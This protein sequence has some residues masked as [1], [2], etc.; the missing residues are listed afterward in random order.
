MY[1]FIRDSYCI[2]EVGS[3]FILRGKALA[4]GDK[5]QYEEME[6]I[7]VIELKTHTQRLALQKDI[8][9]NT[10]ILQYHCDKLQNHIISNFTISDLFQ[11]G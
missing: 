1:G 2:G 4:Y 7:I 8:R 11:H 10:T 3:D 9:D 5:K 6:R